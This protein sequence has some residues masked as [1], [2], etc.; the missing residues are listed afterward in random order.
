MPVSIPHA[1]D[2]VSWPLQLATGRCPPAFLFGR[3]PRSALGTRS[4]RSRCYFREGRS[5]RPQL[6]ASHAPARGHKP[7]RVA[8]AYDP[9]SNYRGISRFSCAP[10]RSIAGALR[11]RPPAIEHIRAALYAPCRARQP[12]KPH[13]AESSSIRVITGVSCLQPHK[14]QLLS[15]PPLR[16]S[17]PPPDPE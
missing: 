5:L 17:R 16:S 1:T 9:R 14:P 13:Y 12:Q 4:S 6:E 7:G 11:Q 8:P 10:V 15:K 3:E 2:P